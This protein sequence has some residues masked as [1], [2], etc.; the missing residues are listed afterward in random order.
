MVQRLVKPTPV[1]LP[2]SSVQ[3][4]DTAE[5]VNQERA[6]SRVRLT[7]FQQGE[8][9][10]IDPPV[11]ETDRS[12]GSQSES[13]DQDQASV[14][15][16][17]NRQSAGQSAPTVGGD[18][19]DTDL[20]PSTRPVM[21][22]DV[23]Q[24]VSDCYPLIDVA[25]GELESA[26]GKILASWGEFD[27]VFSAHSIAQPQGF[28]QTYRNGAGITQPL[29]G[30]GEV[31]GGYRI[32]RG[33]FEPWYGERQTNDGGEF[34]AGF[35]LPL[36]KDRLIDE[37]RAALYA[38]GFMREQVES[39]VQARLLLFQRFS[40][41]AYWETVAAA[42]VVD[43]QQQL[44]ELALERVEQ[45]AARVEA[46]DLP[47]IAQLDNNRFVADRRNSLIKAQRTFEKSAIKLSLFMRDASCR[48]LIL[49]VDQ[50]PDE[51]PGSDLLDEAFVQAGIQQ[52][53]S[54]RPEISELDALRRQVC[55]DRNYAENL[56]LPKL[57]VKGFAGQDVG[58]ASSD[59]RDK[60]PFELQ[61]G[62]FYDVPIQ[63]RE[64]QG[65][66]RV[67]DGKLAQIEA[68]RRFLSE[69]ITT[70]VQDAAS[71]L[72]AAH[73]SIEQAR[74]NLELNQQSLDL[75]EGAFAEGDISLIELNIYETAIA[76]ARLKL[77]DAQLEYVFFT[78]VY[79][80][81]TSGAA[82]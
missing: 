44:L 48:P 68:K 57:D 47:R 14:G 34:K 35:S 18:Q 52:A 27:R 63:R 36:L 53:I 56:T 11:P 19:S 62:V 65:K 39:N 61:V 5:I 28:Y 79:E 58:G 50:L 66:I 46:E 43:T 72:N 69:K 6:R 40:A 42:Q 41:Q 26:D 10:Q 71:A 2:D 82:F 75:A 81:A 32:G 45:I 4:A 38:A 25:I 8:N 76:N 29:F 73:R 51:F 23:L 31:Y 16:A 24:S 80:T 3:S 78:A 7:S 21:L 37:R 64:G 59:K 77:I 17:E 12:Q 70:E 1:K 30:G 49:S 74:K 55:I 13:M 9:Q 15:T 67:A 20:D 54:T 22:D 60:S 33:S